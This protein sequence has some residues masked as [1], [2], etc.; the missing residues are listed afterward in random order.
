MTVR[1]VDT[2]WGREL[3]DALSVDTSKFRV[4][5]PFIKVGALDRLL[6][7]NPGLVRPEA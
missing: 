2:G 7:L 3:T 5:C 4:T 6:S 1:L